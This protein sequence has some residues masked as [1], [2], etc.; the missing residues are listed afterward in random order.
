MMPNFS[1]IYATFAASA[2]RHGDKAA[3][4]YLGTGFSY[5]RVR[6]LAE[7][8]AAALS[9]MGVLAGQRVVLYIPNSIQWVI[10]WLAIQKIGAV[11]VP[12]TPIYTPHD[13]KYIANDSEAE[14]VVCADTN[15]GYVTAALPETRLRRVIVTNVA[16]LLP[17]WKRAFGYLFDVIPRGKFA[18]NK[19][20]YSFKKLL[21]AY[22][23]RARKLPNETRCGKTLAEIL[24][25][26]GTTK[27][28]KGVPFTQSLFLVSSEEQ[29]R[30]SDPLFPADENVIM[31]NAPL[32][33]ILGQTC[34]LATL[35]VGGTLIL[36]PRI[37]LD[38]T[39]DAIQRFRAKTMIGV[40]ALYRMILEHKRLDQY[41]L[42]SLQ[43]CFSGGDVLPVEIG[44]R[45]QE[46]FG[47]F[48]SQGYG[49]TETCGG[50]AM[51]PVD[52]ENPPKS[53]GRIVPSKKVKIV[54]PVTLEPQHL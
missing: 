54:D 10:A 1:D 2:E 8:F 14:T 32:F 24:Y 21:S 5:R 27:F 29:I 15:F 42:S 43:Y 20:T 39:F 35:W 6:E 12:I 23:N 53:V 17:G 44:S 51:C 11:C 18:L 37:N 25:T 50:V 33:H 38:A 28:P 26:G 46:K 41:D 7:C 19:R 9:D 13:L 45:W 30:M 36:Q 34:S 40:P 31:G 22:K 49:A 47:N 52:R 4:I 48:I 16:D 3:V